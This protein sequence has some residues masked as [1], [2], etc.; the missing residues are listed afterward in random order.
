M[1]DPETDILEDIIDLKR[2][3]WWRRWRKCALL[4]APMAKR[5]KALSF[6]LDV[7]A[8]WWRRSDT[9]VRDAA[10]AGRVLLDQLVWVARPQAAATARIKVHRIAALQTVASRLT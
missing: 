7:S 9:I 4:S 5:I 6:G 2:A 10:G 3:G 1:S 8:R